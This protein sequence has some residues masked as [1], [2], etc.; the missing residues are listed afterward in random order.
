MAL[1]RVDIL[2]SGLVQGVFFRA[3]TQEVALKLGLTGWVANQ[4][5]GNV[6]IVCEGEDVQVERFIKWCHQGPNNANVDTVTVT[7]EPYQGDFTDFEIA[8]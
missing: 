4:H 5:D 7:N 1:K 2:I 3:T 6:H 8:F